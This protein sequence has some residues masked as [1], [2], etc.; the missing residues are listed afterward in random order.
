MTFQKKGIAGS[1]ESP[2]KEK[3]SSPRGMCVCVGCVCVR[4][5]TLP[6]FT[7][8]ACRLKLDQETVDRDI[9]RRF[10]SN[11]SLIEVSCEGA[12]LHSAGATGTD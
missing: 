11:V 5:L 8:F 1:C 4:V 6:H 7:C 9:R 2:H 10:G 3:I 12:G